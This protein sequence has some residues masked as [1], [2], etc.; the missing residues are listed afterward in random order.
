MIKFAVTRPDQRLADIQAGI[1][2]LQWGKDVYL[3]NYGLSISPNMIEVGFS[4]G[5]PRVSVADLFIDQGT[6]VA[7]PGCPIQRVHRCSW[8]IREMGSAG[9]KK[10]LDW[11]HQASKLLERFSLPRVIIPWRL[12][13]F[14]SPLIVCITL[15]AIRA[16]ASIGLLC[17]TSSA[18][19]S[20]PIKAMVAASS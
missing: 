8:Y 7:S 18:N 1:N 14:I 2:T 16:E 6:S 19:S 3:K 9:T 4:S 10:V 17:K 11:Q 5:Q 12:K 13:F 15:A 20:K